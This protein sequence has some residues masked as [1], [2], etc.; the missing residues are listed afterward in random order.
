MKAIITALLLIFT[1][2]TFAQ[3][4]SVNVYQPAAGRAPIVA[5]SFRKARDIIQ[6]T[7]VGDAIS[8]DLSGTYRFA[9]VHDS[10]EAYGEWY[11]T[12]QDNAAYAI[13]QAKTVSRAAGTQTDNIPLRTIAAAAPASG[14]GMVTQITVWELTTSNMARLLQA[15]RDSK[16]IHE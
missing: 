8:S 16:V 7:G 15:G 10:W 12:I 13:F 9:T 14:P 3:V 4:V 1:S 2:S 11:A 5:Q 6:A